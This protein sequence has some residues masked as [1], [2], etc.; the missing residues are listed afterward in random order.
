MSRYKNLIAFL[1][2][3][4]EKLHEPTEAVPVHTCGSCDENIFHIGKDGTIL[5]ATCR[6]RVK[7]WHA[8]GTEDRQ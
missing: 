4:N 7:G 6:L 1:F 2:G 8:L 5:C 3:K